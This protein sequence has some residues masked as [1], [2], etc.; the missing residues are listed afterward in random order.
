MDSSPA[1]QALLSAHHLG[2]A[3]NAGFTSVI[4][5]GAPHG[6]DAALKAAVDGGFLR[7][8]RMM[9][10]SRDVGTTGHSQDLSYPWHWGP[11]S[12]PQINR[13]DGAD[14][15]RRAMREE[16]KRGAEIIKIFLSP[17]HGALSGSVDME[18]TW[19][20]LSAAIETAHLRGALVRAHIANKP[21]ILTAVELGIDVVDHGD[22]LD[23][24]CIDLAAGQGQLPL[25]E[26]ALAV[27]HGPGL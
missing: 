20:E 27:P 8:S 7:G 19:E 11:G 26:H 5:A 12:G 17:G 18:L 2:L 13:C 15:F 9:V 6:I 16:I 24:E 3:L 23:E 10:G 25:P 14:G 4:S 1:Q 22:G 21:S